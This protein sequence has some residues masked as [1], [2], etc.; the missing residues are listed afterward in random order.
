MQVVKTLIW[1]KMGVQSMVKQD[2]LI[3]SHYWISGFGASFSLYVKTIVMG[4]ILVIIYVDN[5]IYTSDSDANISEVKLLL[6]HKFEM[7]DSREL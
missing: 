6:K 2:R 4:I 5:L 3:S 1:L 7:K